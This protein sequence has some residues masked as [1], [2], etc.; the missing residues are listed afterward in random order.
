MDEANQKPVYSLSSRDVDYR[1]SRY[2][3]ADY[4]DRER[5]DHRDRERDRSRSRTRDKESRD[6]PT[7]KDRRRDRPAID[8]FGRVINYNRS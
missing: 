4:R 1:R 8:E 2:K 3:D 7:D 6:K 5:D